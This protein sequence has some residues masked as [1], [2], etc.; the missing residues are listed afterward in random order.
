MSKQDE[1]EWSLEMEKFNID[2]EQ[3][4]EQLLEDLDYDKD[5]VPTHIN[6]RSDEWILTTPEHYNQ[7]VNILCQLRDKFRI[8]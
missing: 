5:H 7:V 1:Q 8:I 4:I 3:E 2:S 6:I